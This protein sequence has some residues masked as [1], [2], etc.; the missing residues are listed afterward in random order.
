MNTFIHIG[1]ADVIT[2]D[3]LAVPFIVTTNGVGESHGVTEVS[4]RA[5]RVYVE[6][7]IS[8]VPLRS[9]KLDPNDLRN[10]F[11][12]V[13]AEAKTI[14]PFVMPVTT[15]NEERIAWLMQTYVT[16]GREAWY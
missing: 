11:D 15:A 14:R 1:E 16:G 9:W 12:V 5:G 4:R 8:D 3:D 6:T 10:D 7:T 13:A 2:D